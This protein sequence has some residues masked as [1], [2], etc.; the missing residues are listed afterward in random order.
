[1][2]RTRKN[3]VAALSAVLMSVASQASEW[4]GAN[5]AGAAANGVWSS[6]GQPGWN[7]TGVPNGQGAV[8]YFSSTKKNNVTQDI[9]EGVTLGSLV[10]DLAPN[11]AL[12]LTLNAPSGGSAG[13]IVF[14]QDGEGPESAVISNNAARA[15]VSIASGVPIVL[16]DDLLLINTTDDTHER[17]FSISHTGQISGTGK[18]TI[19]NQLDIPENGPIM[20]AGGTSDFVGDV[21][22]RRGC[23]KVKNNKPFGA[24]ANVVTLGAEGYG[25]ATLCFEGSGVTF[26]YPIVVSQVTSGRLRIHGETLTSSPGKDCVVN[27]TGS[28]KLNGDVVFDI[29]AKPYAATDWTF[30]E[31]IKADISGT[32]AVIKEN[33]GTL[34]IRKV[35][36]ANTY[37]G[38]TVLKAGT[39][40]VE[41]E[42]TLGTGA[43]DVYDGATLD[44]AGD[45]T[46]QSL[47]LNGKLQPKG[48][49]AAADSEETGVI[50][51]AW[52]TG[53][54]KLTA[55]EGKTA[56]LM[57]LVR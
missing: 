36:T 16:N 26:P 51:V 39:L 25:D 52:L 44:L 55:V 7:G 41:N 38:G 20:L 49:Y 27:L 32:G 22:I 43:L 53:S 15:R 19:D 5:D 35:N 42:V 8:A 50:K 14:N 18:L 46:V 4:Y 31:R 1:M 10:L 23:A 13:P 54:G 56:G 24:T 2:I 33:D 11:L 30:E 48:V 3:A 29:P 47:S 9:A 37:A 28:I 40:S 6:N 17:S 12:D 21:L 57:L 45:V 34:V